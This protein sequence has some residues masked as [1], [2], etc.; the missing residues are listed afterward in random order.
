MHSDNNVY[1]VE[2]ITDVVEDLADTVRQVKRR[3]G[4]EGVSAWKEYF[5]I[6]EYSNIS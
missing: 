3:A 1:N 4:G 6:F 2:N 5:N